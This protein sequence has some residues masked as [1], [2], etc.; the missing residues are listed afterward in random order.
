L[1][2]YVGYFYYSKSIN[3][4]IVLIEVKEMM[5]EKSTDV[6]VGT[7]IVNPGAIKVTVVGDGT[8]GKTSLCKSLTEGIITSDYDLT[9]GCEIHSKKINFA[10]S[11][12]AKPLN[13]LIWDFSGQERFHSVRSGL[14]KG[15]KGALMV[16]DITSRGS[17]YDINEWIREFRRN[18]SDAP[19]VLVGNKADKKEREVS[20]EEGEKLAKN[21]GVPYLET[22]A[23]NGENVGMAFE[24]I[25][26]LALTRDN[27]FV[28]Y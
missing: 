11:N 14:Y 7:K 27:R 5:N 22:S 13:L 2:I 10:N 3:Y 18:C 21:L 24:H 4:Q 8:V 1:I 16:F 25:T 15:T 6:G 17:F 19:F 12:T 26:K 23:L 20:R 9:V 28:A